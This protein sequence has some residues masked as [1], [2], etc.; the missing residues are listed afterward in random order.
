M[1]RDSSA[2]RWAPAAGRAG[3]H[4]DAAALCLE[5]ARSR[6]ARALAVLDRGLAQHPEASTVDRAR[7]LLYRAELLTRLA[8][9]DEAATALRAAQTGLT[10]EDA[11]ALRDDLAHARQV[12]DSEQR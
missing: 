12:V 11:E 8:R 10:G 2:G 3:R 9:G 5:R 4:F 1:L 6:D 7:A